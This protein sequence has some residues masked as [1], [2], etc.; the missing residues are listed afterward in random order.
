MV[1]EKTGLEITKK[2]M[3][4]LA[5]Q[6]FETLPEI[7]QGI[8]YSDS[9]KATVLDS[10]RLIV[11]NFE[12]ETFQD[13]LINVNNN[14][15]MDVAAYPYIESEIPNESKVPYR[16]QL[17][18]D[19]VKE[20]ESVLKCIRQL[21]IDHVVIKMEPYNNNTKCFLEAKPNYDYALDLNINLEIGLT[22]M[23]GCKD[24]VVNT[25][26]LLDAIQF[27]KDTKADTIMN[28]NKAH[29][30]LLFN[31]EMPNKFTYDYVVSPGILR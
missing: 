14:Q 7:M 1:V 18:H 13:E 5:K 21:K 28:F 10:F 3:L 20:M 19:T 25:E 4:K 22:M 16:L 6:K 24:I 15:S 26:L 27:V 8:K 17:N 30:T 9:N 29:T 31:G 23:T 12:N 11:V 2:H